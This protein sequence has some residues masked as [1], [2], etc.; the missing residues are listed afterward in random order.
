MVGKIICIG[1]LNFIIW[2]KTSRNF[3]EDSVTNRFWHTVVLRNSLFEL[4]PNDWK[5]QLKNYIQEEYLIQI[6]ENFEKN[7]QK[8]VIFPPE[9][10]LF[11]A[12]KLCRFDQVKVIIIGQDPYHNDGQAHGLAFSVPDGV[13]IPPSLKNIFKELQLEYDSLFFPTSGNLS[14]W[15]AQGVLL[16]N[17]T[18]SVTKNQP[19]SHKDFGWNY[20]TQALIQCLNIEK[21]HLVFLLWGNHAQTFEPRIDASKH[22]ILKAGHPSPLSANQ[23]GWFNS[24]IFLKTNEYLVQNDILPISWLKLN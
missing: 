13:P 9:E 23:G 11:N 18:W 20:F 8:S 4:I 17:S 2:Y 24:G 3:Y 1:F 6:N 22:C 21:S 10:N 19:N 15:A 16:I 12:L 7:K 14:F 5:Y